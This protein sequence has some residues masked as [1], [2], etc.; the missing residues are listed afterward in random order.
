[1]ATQTDRGQGMYLAVEV[2][3]GY[4]RGDGGVS[5]VVLVIPD[6][7]QPQDSKAEAVTTHPEQGAGSSINPEPP[8]GTQQKPNAVQRNPVGY[9]NYPDVPDFGAFIG[10][11][12]SESRSINSTHTT[13]SYLHKDLPNGVPFYEACQNYEQLL[14]EWGFSGRSGE[15]WTK[16][17]GERVCKVVVISS[18][19]G[20]TPDDCIEIGVTIMEK[21]GEASLSISTNIDE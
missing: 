8:N 11:N 21:T 16:D 4:Y 1:M 19:R 14:R 13:F 6:I 2:A 20:F 9:T 7:P 12:L 5:I 10:V 17:F 15:S 3:V 18:A